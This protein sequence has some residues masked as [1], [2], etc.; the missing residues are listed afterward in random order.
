MKKPEVQLCYASA[1]TFGVKVI[2]GKHHQQSDTP[3]SLHIIPEWPIFVR[4]V[5]GDEPLISHHP[6]DLDS[7]SLDLYVQALQLVQKVVL[8][9]RVIQLQPLNSEQPLMTGESV[10]LLKRLIAQLNEETTNETF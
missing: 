4:F 10:A 7:P 3:E 2:W 1:A 9:L 8:V 6:N 5:H